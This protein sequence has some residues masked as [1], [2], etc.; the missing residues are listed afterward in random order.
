MKSEK[1]NK[2]ALHMEKRSS[3]KTKRGIKICRHG[4]VENDQAE[5]VQA[6]VNL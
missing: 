5:N 6:A 2:L 4:F 1:A 3:F